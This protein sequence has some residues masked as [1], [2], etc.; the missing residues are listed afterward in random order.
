MIRDIL[1]NSKVFEQVLRDLKKGVNPHSYLFYSSDEFSAFEMANLTANALICENLCGVCE[2]CLKF[3]NQHSDIK[4]LPQN[5]NQLKVEDSNFVVEESFVKP[6]FFDKKIFVLKNIDKSTPEA[7]NKLLKVL[8]EPNPNVF[9]LL[10]TSNLEKVLP[11]IK[12]RCFKIEVGKFEKNQIAKEISCFDEEIK[13][14]AVK[15]GNGFLGKSIHLSKKKNLQEIFS[16]AKELIFNFKSSK[17][18]L[19]F[20]KKLQK[21]KDDIHLF[22]EIVEIMLEDLIFIKTNMKERVVF[23]IVDEYQKIKEEYSLKAIVQIEKQINF[24]IEKL[25]FNTNQ[26]LVLDN[27]IFKIL[28]VKYLCR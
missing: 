6:I 15:I 1:Q 12:S 13:E 7:Q 14:L 18:L 20:S 5:A 27:L 8:E 17:D 3:R 21:I 26:M 10:S 9:Y 25:S 22:F 24:A 16:F 11:T 28:E 19:S 4:V 2:N 23:D